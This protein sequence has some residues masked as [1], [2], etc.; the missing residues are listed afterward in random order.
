MCLITLILF[1]GANDGIKEVEYQ[2]KNQ[3]TEVFKEWGIYDFLGFSEVENEK[4]GQE[5]F[6]FED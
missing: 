4:T 5:M 1:F 3:Y 2:E 6:V